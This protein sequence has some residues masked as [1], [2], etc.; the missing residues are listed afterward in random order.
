[1]VNEDERCFLMFDFKYKYVRFGPFA[2]KYQTAEKYLL[3]NGFYKLF[4]L[5]LE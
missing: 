3:R 5:K 2:T 1:M 4:N